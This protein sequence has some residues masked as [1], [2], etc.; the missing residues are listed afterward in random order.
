MI[1]TLLRQKNIENKEK[2]QTFFSIHSI[3]AINK[4]CLKTRFVSA[5]RH[6]N[7]FFNHGHFYESLQFYIILSACSTRQQINNLMILL[8]NVSQF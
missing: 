7:H 3:M 8:I 5:S 4:I 6:K 2:M 1:F